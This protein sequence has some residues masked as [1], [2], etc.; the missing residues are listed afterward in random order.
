M[1]RIQNLLLAATIILVSVGLAAA[2]TETDLK[3]YFEG[4]RVEVKIDMP[5]TKDGI[6][7]YSERSQ[8]IDYSRYSSL[9]KNYGI[10]VREGDRILIT[11]IKVKK[12]HIEF[13]LGGGGYGTLGDETS[14]NIYVPSV[15]KTQREKNLERDIKDE[16]D[17]RRRRRMREELS[18]LRRERE[19][20]D[21][22]NRAEVATAEELAKQ[23]IQEKRLQAGSRFNIHFESEL[24][25]RDL[26]PQAIMDALEEYVDFSD[27]DRRQR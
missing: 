21:S 12:K 15:G 20:E 10:S 24:T 3:R 1:K 7:V 11:K 25:A 19:R 5:A 13:Q 22:R 6:D 16:P 27:F 26:T 17:D 4:R 8:P 23:R 9:L 2:Q 18:Y 14:S